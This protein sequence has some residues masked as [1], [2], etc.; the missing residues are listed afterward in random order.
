MTDKAK[1]AFAE[2]T[3]EGA[4]PAL[5]QN[6]GGVV[7]GAGWKLSVYDGSFE[8]KWVLSAADGYSLHIS[9]F[10]DHMIVK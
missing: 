10:I 9:F 6:L 2:G 7:E 5:S 3:A 8:A 1:E 4:A